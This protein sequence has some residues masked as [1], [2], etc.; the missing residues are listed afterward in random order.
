MTPIKMARTRGSINADAFND[1]LKAVKN[2][3]SWDLLVTLTTPKGIET[4]HYEQWTT[5]PDLDALKRFNQLQ[6]MANELRPCVRLLVKVVVENGIASRKIC[7]AVY[8]PMQE[9]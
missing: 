1:F 4:I 5:M 2:S 9:E 8:Y 7:H 6:P 3:Q